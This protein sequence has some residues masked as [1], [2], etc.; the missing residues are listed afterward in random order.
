MQKPNSMKT[1]DLLYLGSLA[2]GLIGLA[3]GWDGLVEQMN[4]EFAA[5]GLDPES[6]FATGAIIGGFVFGIG[7]SLALWF[8]VSILRIE[9]VKWIL[10]LFTVYG[11]VSLAGGI[12]NAGFDPIQITGIV[13]TLMS[14]AAIWMLFKPDSKEW[15]AAKKGAD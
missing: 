4:A 11:V 6:G 12:A 10:V 2:V 7:I 3:L 8:L 14:I 5:Q 13:S 15:F 1:F 9:F